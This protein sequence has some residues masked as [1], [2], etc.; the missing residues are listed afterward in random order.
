M[1]KLA[2][3][4]KTMQDDILGQN[5]GSE[6]M[7]ADPPRGTRSQRLTVYR[8]A[9]VLRLTE[10]LSH[11]YE[12]LRRYM[13][14]SRF[15]QMARAYAA[16]H[17]SD[18]PNARWF[19]RHL[20]AFLSAAAL[21]SRHPELSE[22]AALEQALNDVFDA[23]DAPVVSMAQIS[24]ID[25]A[26]FSDVTFTLTPAVRLLSATTNVSSLWSCLKCEEMPPCAIDLDHPSRLLVWRQGTGSRFRILGEEEAMAVGCLADGLTFGAICEM[27]AAFDDP[28][29]A[30]LRAAGYLR[31]WLEA[32]IISDVALA[33]DPRK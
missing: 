17:P 5:H 25:P 32:E 16:A 23:S 31:G 1:M 19:S 7:I 20:P 15:N 21:Y 11:D 6:S 12:N 24:V 3:I 4:Q 27:I 26:S 2:E 18:N 28:D 14:E 30:A 13:G 10:F 8:N 29:G 9:Y 33:E 22:L